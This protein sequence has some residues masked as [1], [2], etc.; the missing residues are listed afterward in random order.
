[1]STLA[2]VVILFF[3]AASSGLI[4]GRAEQTHK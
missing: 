3:P 1:M 2:R 4:E